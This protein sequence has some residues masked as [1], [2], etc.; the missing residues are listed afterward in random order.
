VQ[1]VGGFWGLSGVWDGFMN[2]D[3]G[4]E[5]ELGEAKKKAAVP[6]FKAQMILAP[7]AAPVL[8]TEVRRVEVKKGVAKETAAKK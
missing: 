4:L 8:K 7:V 2:D 3:D 1:R 5:E 6:A